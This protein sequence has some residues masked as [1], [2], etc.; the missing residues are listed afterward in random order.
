MNIFGTRTG[1]KRTILFL[2]LAASSIITVLTFISRQ[3]AIYWG[4]FIKGSDYGG[5]KP[6]WDHMPLISGEP[7][8]KN[9]N[10]ALGSLLTTL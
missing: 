3:E 8:G 9:L 2:L 1:P 6:S 7:C 10:P 5:G 4:A